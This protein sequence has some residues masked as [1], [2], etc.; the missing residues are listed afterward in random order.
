MLSLTGLSQAATHGRLRRASCRSSRVGHALRV[1]LMPRHTLRVGLISYER[2]RASSQLFGWVRCVQERAKQSHRSFTSASRRSALPL[3]RLHQLS[4]AFE[5][6]ARLP[7]A[8][9]HSP[10]SSA[11]GAS[12][13]LCSWINRR[14]SRCNSPSPTSLRPASASASAT[15]SACRSFGRSGA[16]SCSSSV[17]WVSDR[18]RGLGM[19]MK[20]RPTI[21]GPAAQLLKRICA[22]IARAALIVEGARR[23]RF[24]N[25]SHGQPRG[26]SDQ[27]TASGSIQQCCRRS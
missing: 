14:V 12:K 18:W 2:E 6:I 21:G 13:S 15:N 25:L 19:G 10:R 3:R 4:S 17:N 1:G 8:A 9:G 23:S 24:L 27:T 7:L 26:R 5:R 20:K 16:L 22:R 11:S